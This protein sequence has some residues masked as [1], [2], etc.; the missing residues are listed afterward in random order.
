MYD[1]PGKCYMLRQVALKMICHQLK[2]A[3]LLPGRYSFPCQLYYFCPVFSDG[4]KYL[5]IKVM[6]YYNCVT[7]AGNNSSA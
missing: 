3:Y 7:T 2:K 1:I 6:L 5:Q 4:N